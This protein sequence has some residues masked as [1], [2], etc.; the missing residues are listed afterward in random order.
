MAAAM[1][2][3]A[4][5][6]PQATIWVD[7]DMQRALDRAAS[8][9]GVRV[10]PLTLVAEATVMACAKFPR[11]NARWLDGP[12]AQIQWH[13]HVNVGIA[14]DT[15]RGLLVPSVKGA[16]DL[17]LPDLASLVNALVETARAGKCTPA[18][19]TG[20]TISITNVGV[21]GIDGGTPL[22]NP[23][24]SAIIGMGRIVE[25][26]WVVDGAMEIRPVM[27]VMMTFDHRIVDGA[28]GSRALMSIV[29]E[30]RQAT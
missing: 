27:T 23:G 16:H 25:R 10:T 11:I 22:L 13:D 1:S 18:D 6:A 8:I 19:L 26:P 24:E 15:D 14:V 30:L 9:S 17:T 4:I 29:E 7:V 12:P 20:S 2:V 21:F 5:S 28:T 3:S